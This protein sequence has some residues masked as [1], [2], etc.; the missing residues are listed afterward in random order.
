MNR[1]REQKPI[2]DLRKYARG[3]DCTVRLPGI[4]N[5][6]PATTVLAHFR[7]AGVSGIGMKSPDPIGAWCCSSCHSYADT[8]KDAD[9]QLAFAHG[10]LRTQ[11]ALISEERLLW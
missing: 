4:C 7:L 3:K 2:T 5:G 10:V 9:T 6:D 11:A 8:H 1:R